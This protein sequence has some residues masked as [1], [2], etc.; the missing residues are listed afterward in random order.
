MRGRQVQNA[1]V[2]TWHLRSACDCDM[3]CQLQGTFL[4]GGAL[5]SVCCVEDSV[6]ESV[7][8][9]LASGSPPRKAKWVSSKQRI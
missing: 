2:N 1:P 9:P 6:N 4:W 8:P 3:F 7:L 5:P